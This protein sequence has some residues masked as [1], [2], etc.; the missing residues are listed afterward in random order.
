MLIIDYSRRCEFND[1]NKF[2]VESVQSTCA[3]FA[4]RLFT[5]MDGMGTDDATLIRIIVSRS[6][7]DLGSIKS[8]FERLY[9]RTLLSAVKV[10]VS[11]CSVCHEIV[12]KS[13]F[14]Y[15][16]KHLEII[17]TPYAVLLAQLSS[18]KVNYTTN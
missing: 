1:I 5:A 12:F 9:D 16:V 11:R 6:E 3:F 4:K 2:L 18:A 15:R 8:E 17:N 7:I 14:Y 10:I 13:K